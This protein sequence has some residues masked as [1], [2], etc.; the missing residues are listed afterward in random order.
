MSISKSRNE[1]ELERNNLRR[2][3]GERERSILADALPIV[4]GPVLGATFGHF[5]HFQMSQKGL[6]L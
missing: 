1:T 4:E 3:K 5:A 2:E 6:N